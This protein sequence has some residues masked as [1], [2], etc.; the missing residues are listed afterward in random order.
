MSPRVADPHWFNAYPD[1]AFFLFADPDPFL[2]PGFWWLK[3]GKN[4][5]L[6]IFYIFFWS[7]IAI[8]IFLGLCKGRP[9]YRRSF[10]S[11]KENIQQFKTCPGS[12]SGSSKSA[13]Q[14]NADPCGS[15]PQPWCSPY[16]PKMERSSE[17][18]WPNSKLS[19][20][21]SSDR[22]AAWA[23]QRSSDQQKDWQSEMD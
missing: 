19:S 14:I 16:L 7:K 1:P 5:K 15:D 2:D 10:Q 4:L 3:I 13:T 12:G 20:A 21:I 22:Q 11:S 9:S 18:W 23:N 8:Y 6:K 17:T